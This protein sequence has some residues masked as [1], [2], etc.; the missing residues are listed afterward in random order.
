MKP[1]A[2]KSR[3]I[4]VILF[5]SSFYLL[6]CQ[7]E[8]DPNTLS[9]GGGNGGGGN[10]TQSSFHPT[11]VGS[12]WKYKDTATGSISTSTILNRTKT[13]N[14]ILYTAMLGE[15]SVQRDTAWIASPQ[16]N[17]YMYEKGTSP[18][19]GGTYDVT[20]HY[21][22]DTASVGYNWQYMA[23]QGNGFTAYIQTIII[24]RNIS[25]TVAGKSFNNVIH[26]RMIWSYDILGTVMEFLSYDYFI[27]KGVGIIKV[28]SEGQNLLAGFKACTDLVDY[29]IK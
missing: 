6:S 12:W 13:I 14:G 8:V 15:N 23:G 10:N 28:R 5:F 17:Y 19:T 25:M 1:T 21:L 11:S 20:F 9:P 26:S 7:K 29:S 27:A 22:N 3:G 24:E 18:N 16:P 2:I 4:A